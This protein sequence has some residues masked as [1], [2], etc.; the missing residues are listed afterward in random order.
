MGVRADPPKP[1]RSTARCLIG[2]SGLF[3]AGLIASPVRADLAPPPSAADLDRM[4][5]EDLAKIDVSSVSK[6]VEP[7]SDAAS[8]I[9]VITHEEIMRSGETNLA[10][11]LRLAPNLQV[12]QINAG[13]FAI[14]ARGFNGPS[15]SKLLVLIDGRSVYSSY[16]HGVY[17]DVQ[18]IPPEDIER[19]EVI[20]GPGATIWGANAVNGVI[21]IITRKA[22]DTP[23]G[24]LELSG[25]DHSRQA[26]LQYGGRLGDDLSFRAY[27]DGVEFSNDKTAT[28]LSA[29]DAWRRRQDGFRIDWSP[30]RDLV[31]VQGDL[32]HG[33]EDRFASAAQEVSGQDLLARW[34]RT[35]DGEGMLQVQAYYD[36]TR[37]TVA[38]VFDEVQRTYDIETQ[39]NLA[40][41]ARQQLV[42]GAGFRQTIDDYASPAANLSSPFVTF[43]RPANRSMLQGDVFAQDTIAL[44]GSLKLIAGL[45]LE[46]D[47]YVAVEPLPSV[48]LS[49]KIDNQSL[50]WAAISRAIRAPSRLDRDL[51]V[52]AGGKPYVVGDQFVS[53]KLIAY[54]IGYRIQPVSRLS[55]SI[56]AYYNVYQ[57]LR[58]IEPTPRT[59]TPLRIENGMEGETYGLEAWSSYQ[60]FDWWRL[61]VGGDWMHE[62]L[63]FKP[64]S[65]GLGGVQIAGDDPHYQATA[66]SLM[67]LGHRVDLGLDLR[68]VG[69]LP[70]PAAPAYVEA[71]ARLSW[72]IT[73]AVEVSLRGDN[74]LNPH[75]L[76]FGSAAVL[77]LP[78][79]V[80]VDVQRSWS[81][82]TR[83]R[84]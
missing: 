39:Q 21:N 45:K 75:H 83:L 47:P 59:F 6:T 69:A 22:S 3:L 68:T 10:D 51:F 25:G 65:R 74:L 40:L 76:E 27:A 55:A 67:N 80:R 56:S 28:G 14:S 35:T 44:S 54:E 37:R 81:L 26:S 41:G 31:T 52:N 11:I 24:F 17:W 53:E 64:G 78:G 70:A 42:W 62:D 4:P 20:S 30:G 9:Y 34:T 32:Y 12:A 60:V 15:A 79:S 77:V 50:L 48:R 84:F 82:A 38:R 2:A 73:D 29:N 71:D 23:G 61:S 72:A 36:D 57:D 43:F 13:A 66:Q 8:A 46:D 19:I 63:R 16:D 58:S 18:D 49:W 33:R 5:I 1:V 7:L